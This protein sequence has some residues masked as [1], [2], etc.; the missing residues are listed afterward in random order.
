LSQRF[1]ESGFPGNLG[2][3]P[4]LGRAGECDRG[5]AP[6]SQLADERLDAVGVGF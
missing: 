4:D 1:G 5:K 2:K 6:L 3:P